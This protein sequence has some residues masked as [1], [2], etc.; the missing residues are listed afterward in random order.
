MT[1]V[2]DGPL[3]E[4]LELLFVLLL[5]PWRTWT[6]SSSE[7]LSVKSTWNECDKRFFNIFPVKN[8]IDALKKGALFTKLPS[9]PL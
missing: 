2:A 4:A 8:Q 5:F 9:L 3:F 6:H 7:S 1:G